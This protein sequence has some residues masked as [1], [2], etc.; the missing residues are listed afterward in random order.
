MNR[1]INRDSRR[2]FD[3]GPI[4]GLL[5]QEY[6]HPDVPP[7][8]SEQAITF[9]IAA[10]D[11]FDDTLD[12]AILVMLFEREDDRAESARS[13]LTFDALTPIAIEQF[14]KHWTDCCAKVDAPPS[15]PSCIE[16]SFAVSDEWN[17]KFYVARSK[18]TYY[19]VCWSTTA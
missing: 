16:M 19:A 13:T 1:F 2:S 10:T 17:D 14:I 6:W 18:D 12:F 9:F 3:E 11:S 5:I 7:H 8:G 15:T 4:A